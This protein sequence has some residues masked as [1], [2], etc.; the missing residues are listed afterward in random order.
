MYLKGK[1]YC[2]FKYILIF[3]LLFTLNIFYII[4]FRETEKESKAKNKKR[5]INWL[6]FLVLGDVNLN[7]K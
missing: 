5:V 7:S 2:H 4:Y 3:P 1:K 6:M